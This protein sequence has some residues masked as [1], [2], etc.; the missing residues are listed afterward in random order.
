MYIAERSILFIDS[1]SYAIKSDGAPLTQNKRAQHLFSNDDRIY[2]NT[3]YPQTFHIKIHDR[4]NCSSQRLYPILI[5]HRLL[6]LFNF[7]SCN[8]NI[9]A[10]VN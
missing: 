2:R 10:D 3:K 6:G 4:T 5:N 9:V 7:A 8:F 1:K